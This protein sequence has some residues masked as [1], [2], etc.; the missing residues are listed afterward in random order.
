VCEDAAGDFDFLALVTCTMSELG[1]GER[2]RGD[3]AGD[4]DFLALVTMCELGDGERLREDAAGE[5]AW[6]MA[7]AV[8]LLAILFLFLIPLARAWSLTAASAAS[9]YFSFNISFTRLVS[10]PASKSQDRK[11]S[12]ARTL[13]KRRIGPFCG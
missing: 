12:S 2:L 11:D 5:R 1:D 10:R 13:F 7:A 6:N 3:V 9:L 4:F 8:P